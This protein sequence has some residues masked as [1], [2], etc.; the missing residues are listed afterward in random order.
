MVSG[1]PV[2]SVLNDYPPLI[3]DL[4]G[5]EHPE[6]IVQNQNGEVLVI[7]WKGEIQ[8]RLTEYGSLICLAEFQGKNAIVTEST[9]WLFGDVSNNTGNEW[10]TRNHNF[11]N[12]RTLQLQNPKIP[13]QTILMDKSK[14]YVYPN[15]AYDDQ[16]KFRIAIESAEKVDIMIY[17]LA[18]YYIKKIDFEN[19][20]KGAIEEKVWNVEDVEPGVYFANVTAWK[21]E[22]SETL[23]LKVAVVH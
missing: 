21:D 22:N 10:I 1:F 17:D 8:Y 13:Y 3:K 5:D 12:T 14:T 6:I 4:Y 16:V 11:G 18:G 23:I 7:N 20:I 19:P 2:D 15:P 9:V